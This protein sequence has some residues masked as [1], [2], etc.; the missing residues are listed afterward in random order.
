M[1][2]KILILVTV[3]PLFTA[4][5]Q[6]T[7]IWIRAQAAANELPV[8]IIPKFFNLIFVENPGAAWGL[9]R[10]HEHRLTIFLVVSVVAFV[11]IGLYYRSLTERDGW[12]AVALSMILSGA[13]GNFIDRA[14][15]GKVTDFFDFH[16]G[17]AG[18]LRDFTLDRWRT[19]HYPTFNVADVAIVL[20]VAVFLFHVLV[21]ETLR[22]RG[23][24][25]AEQES[26]S[27]PGSERTAAPSE[28]DPD[29]AETASE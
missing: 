11:V 24:G 20:G 23:A 15:F 13:I 6:L 18:T 12:L 27:E 21:I 17:W 10:D 7:K 9:M 26:E 19:S 25:D 14:L 3:V 4:L 29:A 1:S 8:E 16:V 2:R 5:D 28:S 22:G